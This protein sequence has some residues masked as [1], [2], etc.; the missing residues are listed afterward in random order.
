MTAMPLALVHAMSYLYLQACGTM[1][2]PALLPN[3]VQNLL[4]ASGHMSGRDWAAAMLKLFGDFFD[5]KQSAMSSGIHTIIDQIQTFVQEH[6]KE[7]IHLSSIAEVF[8]YSPSYLSRLYKEETNNN[9]S[10]YIIMIRL[11]F[12]KNLLRKTSMSIRDI[13]H[14][15]GFYSVKY[16]TQ[17]FKKYNHEITPGQYRNGME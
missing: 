11:N 15:S 8:H 16:F 5:H 10:T 4:D 12:A 1:Q 13:A 3:Y 14:E 9:L 6:F 2:Q 17:A 7:D